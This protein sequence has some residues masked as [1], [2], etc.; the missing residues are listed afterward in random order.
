MY[1]GVIYFKNSIF[2]WLE[3]YKLCLTN[4]TMNLES[5]FYSSSLH[6]LLFYN[7]SSFTISKVNNCLCYMYKC[8]STKCLVMYFIFINSMSI[9]VCNMKYDT[10][11]VDLKARKDLSTNE[12]MNW[13][14]KGGLNSLLFYSKDKLFRLWCPSRIFY[15][16][17]KA[18]E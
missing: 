9:K 10:K 18:K 7:S 2:P 15:K 8:H 1:R 17:M 16:I 13:C 12:D 5:L 11:F 14:L 3:H 4:N 6:H